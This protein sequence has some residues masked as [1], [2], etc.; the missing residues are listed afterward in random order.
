MSRLFQNNGD[1]GVGFDAG[2][3][4]QHDDL[5]GVA[6]ADLDRRLS[7]RIVDRPQQIAGGD[8]V[9]QFDGRF[10]EASPG[11]GVVD[12]HVT[13]RGTVIFDHPLA[14]GHLGGR[15]GQQ[16]E[17]GQDV[18]AA[19][20]VRL[21]PVG[22][23]LAPPEVLAVDGGNVVV[24]GDREGPAVEAPVGPPDQGQPE[25]L[26]HPALLFEH[27]GIAMQHVA[28]EGQHLQP[29]A[30]GVQID[31]EIGLRDLGGEGVGGLFGER[32]IRPARAGAGEIEAI[33]G[34]AGPPGERPFVD[35]GN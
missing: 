17:V 31:V 18:L 2:V 35:D 32:P 6:G 33:F 4:V 11:G 26:S 15:A 30:A 1:A 24:A 22:G 29:G 21:D 19:P 7:Q 10:E 8:A 12:L 13:R 14:G 9:P 3:G 27:A 16:A 34:G 23:E 28:R 25:D 20:H 5:A